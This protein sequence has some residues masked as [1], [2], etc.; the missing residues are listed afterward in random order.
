MTFDGTKFGAI[1]SA[2]YQDGRPMDEVLRRKIEGNRAHLQALTPPV[3]VMRRGGDA[4]PDDTGA[5]YGD[6]AICSF[7]K[8]VFLVVPVWI[9]PTTTAVKIGLALRTAGNGEVY[10]GARVVWAG[11]T[12]RVLGTL[13][14]FSIEDDNPFSVTG[15]TE[16]TIPVR[17]S[18]DA[19]YAL[20]YCTIRS[21]LQD[22]VPTKVADSVSNFMQGGVSLFRWPAFNPAYV[23]ATSP[24]TADVLA[25]DHAALVDEQNNGRSD[26]LA[27]YVV[28]D[29]VT[30]VQAKLTVGT[31]PLHT[32][33]GTQ[34]MSYMQLRSYYVQTAHDVQL[35]TA[36]LAAGLPEGAEESM[37]QAQQLQAIRNR[38]R[39]LAAG[40]E[41]WRP[42]LA[43]SERQNTQGRH[44]QVWRYTR[45]STPGDIVRAFVPDYAADGRIEVV[46]VLA[47]HWHE[48][49]LDE[50]IGTV[51]WDLELVVDSFVDTETTEITQP[52]A[53]LGT[54]D[55]WQPQGVAGN[56]YLPAMM[57]ALNQDAEPFQPGFYVVKDGQFLE[58]E[59]NDFSVVRISAPVPTLSG[60]GMTVRVAANVNP[61]PNIQGLGGGAD[62]ITKQMLTCVAWSVFWRPA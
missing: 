42:E 35:M 14:E 50:D 48:G 3:V 58:A 29:F 7:A 15:I 16:L 21:T 39:L 41:G 1:D 55:A 33:I 34:P 49:Q 30:L 36:E 19:G 45:G 5:F 44:Y 61:A 10:V 24:S 2:A 56:R 11:N 18:G 32:V 31:L 28:N 20:A 8:T 22:E 47:A 9:E 54:A 43:T 23:P 17:A 25:L 46:M 13:D 62:R 37:R 6:R 60:V 12:R 27:F 26:I 59:L 4:A 52:I 53:C 38:P 51:N 40:P 57:R